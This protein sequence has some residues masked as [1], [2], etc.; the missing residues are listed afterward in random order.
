MSD[1]EYARHH[2]HRNIHE[3]CTSEMS[4]QKLSRLTADMESFTSG[5]LPFS[6]DAAV[7][8]C[9]DEE[10]ID[11]MKVIIT[12]SSGTPYAFGLF[13]FDV[14]MT[15]Q[16]P[17]HPPMV[18]LCTTGKGTF[19]FNP[20]L[21]SDGKVCLSLL[22][23]FDG[24]KEE[25]WNPKKGPTQSTLFQVLVAIQSSIL[26]EE[27]YFNEP[28]Y[29]QDRGTAHGEALRNAY[30]ER[31]RVATVNHAMVGMLREPPQGME[32]LVKAHFTLLRG[33]IMQECKGWLRL[34]EG[35]EN[36]G[37]L[38]DAVTA[39]QV[40]LLKLGPID[41]A[42]ANANGATSGAEKDAVKESPGKTSSEAK[43][44]K[45]MP[46]KKAPGEEPRNS[47]MDVDAAMERDL[48][49]A[50]ALSMEAVADGHHPTAGAD[51]QS[52]M[53]ELE[54][55]NIAEAIALSMQSSQPNAQ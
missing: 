30:N 29:E 18:H 42:P 46:G 32:A 5:D 39:L 22:G 26:V 17:N 15:N 51:D 9:A 38:V 28:G 16:Y 33:R 20:N 49:A 13:E 37:A 10:R 8:V 2:F 1:D 43:A 31:I 40:E 24:A 11:V 14:F 54:A 50:M 52:A 41:R 12:G 25:Q 48:A 21:Y 36:R 6:A 27:P 4:S 45:N 19:R 53:Q 44:S 3:S 55:R 34:A 35:S 47:A 7:F 23:T